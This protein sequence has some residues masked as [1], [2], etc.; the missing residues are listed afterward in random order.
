MTMR[1]AIIY[2]KDLFK[3]RKKFAQISRDS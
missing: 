2:L 3:E 1:V